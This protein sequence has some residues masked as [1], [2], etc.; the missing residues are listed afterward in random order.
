M[1]FDSLGSA[2]RDGEVRL[3]GPL[4]GRY[5]GEGRV[6]VC[7]NQEWGRVCGDEW[8]E[9]DATVVCRQLGFSG[10]ATTKGDLILAILHFLY[11]Y[12]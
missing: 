7:R 3:V 4:G 9:S 6:E 12:S 2:C 8:D 10:G 5:S 1:T 11:I